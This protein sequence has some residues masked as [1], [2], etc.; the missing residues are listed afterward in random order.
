MKAIIVGIDSRI[1][2]ALGEALVSGGHQVHGTSRRQ[3]A[4]SKGHQHLDLADP[5]VE[6]LS[7]P[8]A[9][10]AFFCAAITRY[11]DC[12]ASPLLARRVNVLT[13]ALLARQL[14]GR[15]T[16][17]VLLSTS[18]VYDGLSPNVPASRPPIPVTDYGRLKAEAEAE[19]LAL[20]R[21]AAVVRLTKVLEPNHALFGGWISGLASGG[22]ISAF[23]DLGLAPIS[24]EE[25]VVALMTVAATPEN[26]IYQVSASRDI[27]YVD[28]ARHVALRLGADP[29]CVIAR[30]GAEAGVPAEQ[31]TLFS[32]LDA[33]RLT[34]LT[35]RAAPDPFAVIDGV[36][37]PAFVRS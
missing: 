16:R 9:D 10:I 23:S 28:A 4:V 1:G 8:S 21:A 5:G 14:S 19:F 34:A 11:A 2:Q 33:S 15:G 13:P 36:F 35:G 22:T 27:S 32:S 24:I 25:T 17:V 3:D 26:G 7:L 20:G 6:R 18:A 37:G 30:G 29:E 12:R 31:L